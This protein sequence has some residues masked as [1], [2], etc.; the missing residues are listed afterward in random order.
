MF[1]LR[2]CAARLLVGLALIACV[3]IPAL[4]ASDAIVEAKRR[5]ANDLIRSNKTADGIALL[6]EVVALD[7]KNFR[8]FL[9]LARAHD[10]LNATA[11]ALA[12]YRKVLALVPVDAKLPE[13][14]S[15]RGEAER[16]VKVLDQQSAKIDAAVEEA[17]R[18][19]IALEKEAET[20]RATSSAERL[21]RI[22]AAILQADARPDRGGAEVPATRF[23]WTNTNFNVQKGKSY[24]VVCKGMWRLGPRPTDECSADGLPNREYN[25]RPLGTIVASISGGASEFTALGRDSTFV[26]PTTGLLIVNCWEKGEDK[27]DNS[28]SIFLLID[29]VK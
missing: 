21:Y 2:P 20:A 25:G 12:A 19:L 14:R 9:A 28:G 22:H 1:T 26:A 11:D 18:K 29:E 13:E 27:K 10:K 16:R 15:A 24:H 6:R 23:E 7:D 17:L 5:A 8:D 4:A 3:A